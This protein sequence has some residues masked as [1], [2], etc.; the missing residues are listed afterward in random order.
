MRAAAAQIESAPN[1]L[2]ANLVKHRDAID[3]ARTAGVDVLVFPELSLTGHSSGAHAS[4]LAVT[5]DH[6]HVTALARA[7]GGMLTLFGG[8]ER[9][10]HGFHNAIFAVRNGD[11]VHVHRKVNLATYGRLDDGKHF[12]AGPGIHTFD[13]DTSWRAAPMICADTWN[14]PLVHLA[15]VQGASLMPVAVSSALEAVG[16]DFDNPS[17]WDINLRFHALTYG[18]AIVMANRVGSEDGMT[19]WGGSRV[20]DPFGSTIA[21]AAGASE[22]LV[23][24]DLERNDVDRAR[25]LLPT[26]RDSDLPLLQ[27]ETSRLL[28]EMSRVA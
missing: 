18:L 27:R 23:C 22:Q 7:S 9:G 13:I 4:R 6:S 14:P 3:A 24:A 21:A 5:S 26:V 10:I 19:F 15:A 11:V 16:G 17:G 2:E 20:M 12:I 8:I 1:D 28:R 25:E